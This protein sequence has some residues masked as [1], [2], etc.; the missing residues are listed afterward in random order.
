M[1][2]DW[3]FLCR[4]P[5]KTKIPIF[6][7]WGDSWVLFPFIR[8]SENKKR[9][10]SQPHASCID[11]SLWHA[12]RACMFPI[13]VA[14]FFFFLLFALVAL[15]HTQE[16]WCRPSFGWLAL[17]S[18]LPPS[19]FLFFYFIFFL[20]KN[21]QLVDSRNGGVSASAEN[22]H[23]WRLTRKKRDIFFYGIPF[24]LLFFF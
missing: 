2:I 4:I 13:P 3:L 16:T 15:D 24:S 5:S 6:V 9:R 10:G 19:S 20:G 11:D 22:L 14:H 1:C 12:G 17:S 23:A 7:R 8:T 18:P 21:F